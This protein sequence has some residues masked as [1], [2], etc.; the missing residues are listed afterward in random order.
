MLNAIK[1]RKISSRIVA[2]ALSIFAVVSAMPLASAANVSEATEPAYMMVV[3][4]EENIAAY[5]EAGIIRSCSVIANTQETRSASAGFVIMGTSIPTTVWNLYDQGYRS[6]TYNMS[7][8]IYSNYLYDPGNYSDIWHSISPDQVQSLRINGY[9]SNGTAW[10]SHTITNSDEDF[11]WGVATPTGY[12][13]YFKYTSVNG[14]LISGSGS[15][16]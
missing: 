15:V 16:A 4:G 12:T 13:Y 2:V 7:T 10:G 14:A 3:S 9:K 8:Y 5:K 6:V 1:L 11:A